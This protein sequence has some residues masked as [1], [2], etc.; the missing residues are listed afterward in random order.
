MKKIS[1]I[2]I[3]AVFSAIA[4]GQT[5]KLINPADL[6]QQTVITEPLTLQKGFL[7]VGLFY[8]YIIQDKYFDESSKKVYYPGSSWATSNDL[9][10]SIEYGITDRLT[11]E[12]GIPYKDDI[13]TMHLEEYDPSINGTISSNFSSKGKGIGDMTVQATYQVIPSKDHKLSLRADME[14][15][16][17]T[18]SKNPTNVVNYFEY[19]LPTGDGAFVVSPG[20][21]ARL[22]SYPFSFTAFLYY[23]YNFTEH[24]II[25]VGDPEEKEYKYGNNILTGGSLNFQLNE[26]IAL[27]N[28]L[29]YY[30]CGKGEEEDVSTNDL[31]TS[32]TVTYSPNLIFQIRRF[33][34]GESV[35]IPLKGK[36]YSADPEFTLFV[37]YVF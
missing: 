15:T 27:T 9:D 6:K 17:P 28:E 35:S 25:N 20:L 5:E 29:D 3:F 36:M 23:N 31:N 33:R 24:K 37:Q 12:L 1:I 21:Y 26:W 34:L 32:W 7:R 18:G 14:A 11:V 13:R 16:F 4:Y 10:L 2:S 19:N 30:Y 8:N 22:L